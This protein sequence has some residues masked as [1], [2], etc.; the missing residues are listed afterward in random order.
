[1]NFNQAHNFVFQHLVEFS[2]FNCVFCSTKEKQSGKA[3]LF[4]IFKDKGRVYMRNGIK[5]T[6]EKVTDPKVQLDVQE[7]FKKVIKERKIPAFKHASELGHDQT[8]NH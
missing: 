7:S 4:L 8:T 2:N 1:M 6:W 3:R 5:G